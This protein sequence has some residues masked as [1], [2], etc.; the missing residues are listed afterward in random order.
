VVPGAIGKYNINLGIPSLQS[1]Q[2]FKNL[3]HS[4]YLDGLCIAAT[5]RTT[6]VKVLQIVFEYCIMYIYYEIVH[7]ENTQKTQR[8]EKIQ[9]KSKQTCLQTHLNQ[10]NA[11]N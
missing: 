8:T 10:L 11:K 3:K 4:Q 9:I 6:H 7:R 5:T 2:A 1:N